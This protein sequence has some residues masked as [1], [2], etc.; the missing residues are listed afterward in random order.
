MVQAQK[1]FPFFPRVTEQLRII[2]SHPFYMEPDVWGSLLKAKWSNP[3]PPVRF[4]VDWRETSDQGLVSCVLSMHPWLQTPMQSVRVCS[5]GAP[6]RWTMA[7]L[8]NHTFILENNPGRRASETSVLHRII[9]PRQP[10]THFNRQHTLVKMGL[11]GRLSLQH[12]LTS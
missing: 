4:H 3:R 10:Y 5:I 2:P 8:F 6:L 7:G 9:F 11:Q 12:A 1:G